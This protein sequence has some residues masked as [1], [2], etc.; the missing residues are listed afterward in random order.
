MKRMTTK[1]LPKRAAQSPDG[2]IQASKK[3][4]HEFR[5]LSDSQVAGKVVTGIG[6][7]KNTLRL[8]LGGKEWLEISCKDTVF[9]VSLR[10]TSGVGALPGCYAKDDQLAISLDEHEFAW[11]PCEPLSKYIGATASTLWFGENSLLIY[12]S[13]DLPILQC[14]A[15]LESSHQEYVLFWEQVE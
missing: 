5:T 4:D 8:E 2:A 6:G 14:S 15:L 12:F 3:I 13:G 1:S 11:V 7:N 10:N 9:Q